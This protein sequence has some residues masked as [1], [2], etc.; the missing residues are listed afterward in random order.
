[1]QR[2]YFL[3]FLIYTSRMTLQTSQKRPFMY[4]VF[5]R[6]FHCRWIWIILAKQESLQRV[7]PIPN[8]ASPL[9][10]RLR[11]GPFWFLLNTQIW[12]LNCPSSVP[13]NTTALLS[14]SLQLRNSVLAWGPTSGA[15]QFYKCK[16][17]PLCPYSTLVESTSA[18][19]LSQCFRRLK[20]T[21]GKIVAS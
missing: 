18:K 11:S 15:P 10:Y 2:L 8:K 19:N 13:G 7:P 21:F 17:H 9:V 14:Q 1:M 5:W 16:R 6:F 3:R 4:H 12:F 20:K